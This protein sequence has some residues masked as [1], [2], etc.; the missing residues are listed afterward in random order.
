MFRCISCGSKS[1]L[2]YAVLEGYP[3]LQCH[4]CGLLSTNAS[5]LAIKKYV[6][7][8]YNDEYAK[9]Y[10]QALS[11][12]HKR[13]AQHLLLIKKYTSGN[14]LLDI[15]CG[16]GHF[17]KYLIS[18]KGLWDLFGVEPSMLLRKVA[19]KN[20]SVNIRK[21][22]LNNIPF[23]DNYFD[24][25]TCYDVLEHNIKLKENVAELRRVLKP[26]GI[27][28]IQ[29]PNYKSLMAY[30]TGKRWDWWCVPDHVLHFSYKFLT[31]YMKDNGFTILRSYTYED[32]EDFLSNIKGV[33]GRNYF[34]KA[35][36]YLLIPLLL[37]IERLGWVVN[38]GG[39]SL[40]LVKKN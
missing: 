20:T 25:V 38:M 14:R 15:G 7:R 10:S 5:K 8:K 30:I 40:L 1:Y 37:V 6:A 11:K 39:L 33:L 18:D 21:G 35:S 24:I 36:Y 32:Q 19:R 31:G 17:L 34:T 9:N 16:T 12:L 27:L 28:L 3:L 23:R 2:R 22:K 4:R 26:N 13:Y 29:A